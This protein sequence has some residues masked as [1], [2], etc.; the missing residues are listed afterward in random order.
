MAVENRR[1][2]VAIEANVLH[3]GSKKWNDESFLPTTSVKDVHSDFA[4]L[5][6]IPFDAICH[7]QPATPEK[8]EEK[9]N[10]MNL[11]LNCGIQNWE[12]SGHCGGGH[13]GDDDNDS[14]DDGNDGGTNGDENR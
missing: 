12:R 2:A 11:A 5:I 7:F 1:T 8:V 14:D 10:A 9:W 3:M 6:P 4:W 13:T